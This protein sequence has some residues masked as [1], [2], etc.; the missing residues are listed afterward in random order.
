M[1]ILWP[2]ILALILLVLASIA[3]IKQKAALGTF[4]DS[5]NW[6]GPGHSPEQQVMGAAAF[7]ILLVGF[8]V[9]IRA[10]S[11]NR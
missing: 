7:I 11:R 9:A 3:F 4:F 1:R 5:L 6:I 10:L 2:N 8:V